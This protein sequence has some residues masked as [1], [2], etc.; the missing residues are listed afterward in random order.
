MPDVHQDPDGH[1]AWIAGQVRDQVMREVRQA[2]ERYGAMTRAEVS[3][4]LARQKYED[5]EQK[6]EVFKQAMIENPFLIDQVRRAPDPANFAYRAAGQYLE[7]KQ[8]GS[9]ATSS[10]G[11]IEAEIRQQIMSEL[12]LS[13]APRAPSSLVSER[14]VGARSGPAWAG[15]TSLGDILS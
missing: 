5:Y 4:L 12:G 10:R 1:A 7:A 14:S 15:P 13:S 8:H 11:A 2:G 3:E 6:I 9:S